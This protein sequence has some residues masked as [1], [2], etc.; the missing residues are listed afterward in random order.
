[1][2]SGLV[3]HSAKKSCTFWLGAFWNFPSPFLHITPFSFFALQNCKVL[4]ATSTDQIAASW[5][6]L[7]GA[8]IPTMGNSRNAVAQQ[9]R[10]VGH[11]RIEASTNPPY[12]SGKHKLMMCISKAISPRS[13]NQAAGNAAFPPHNRVCALFCSLYGELCSAFAPREPVRIDTEIVKLMKQGST[14]NVCNQATVLWLD[15]EMSM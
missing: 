8:T 11:C 3:M 9:S 12:F 15:H 4:W 1:M 13:L 2:A 6:L 14:S 7:V 5:H 10:I